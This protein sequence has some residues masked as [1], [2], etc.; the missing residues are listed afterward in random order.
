MIAIVS[1]IHGNLEALRAVLADAERQGAEAVYCLGDVIGYGP[2]PRECLDLAQGFRLTILGNHDQGALFD[3]AGFSPSAERAIFWTRQQLETSPGPR[4]ERER[5]WEF[6]AERPR[7]HKED[8]YLF[9]HGSARNPL[10]EYVFPEDIYNQRKMER[11]FALVERYCFQGHTHVPGVFVEETPGG[12]YHFHGPEEV[13]FAYRLDGRKTL[14]NVGSVGQPRDGDPRACYAL[15][16]GEVIRYRRV[17]YDVDETIRKIH[18]IPD[19][20]RLLGDR[21]REGR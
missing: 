16:D 12:P 1:D 2:N 9:V 11:L 8:G 14:V 7:F 17:E 19:L 15:C 13:E 4:Q 21:L 6:L 10:D 18:A 5:R 3:P 20:D